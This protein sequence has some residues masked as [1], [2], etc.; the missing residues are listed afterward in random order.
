MLHY[1][2]YL[3][4]K[5]KISYTD[6]QCFPVLFMLLVNKH[7]KCRFVKLNEK[8]GMMEEQKVD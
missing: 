2:A 4:Q 3:K 5:C 8:T 6:Q 7:I 1:C